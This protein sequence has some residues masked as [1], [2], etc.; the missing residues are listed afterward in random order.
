MHTTK[1]CH[2]AQNL[3]FFFFV[4]LS[5]S[6]TYKEKKKPKNISFPCSH[7]LLLARTRAAA[8]LAWIHPVLSVLGNAADS[9]WISPWSWHQWSTQSPHPR[10]DNGLRTP[11]ESEGFWLYYCCWPPG[12]EL[13]GGKI[14]WIGKKKS[15][16]GMDDLTCP[17]THTPRC[18]NICN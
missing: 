10:A 4:F 12:K 1:G 16:K 13:G 15:L 3:E 2:M 8:M 18:R 14:F 11:D 6:D 7:F 5:Y 9:S 17:H